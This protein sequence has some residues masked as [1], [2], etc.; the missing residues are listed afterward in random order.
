MGR[1]EKGGEDGRRGEMEEEDGEEC[2][3]TGKWE[4]KRVEGRRSRRQSAVC[5]ARE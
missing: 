4:E 5:S 3:W 2:R 1:E